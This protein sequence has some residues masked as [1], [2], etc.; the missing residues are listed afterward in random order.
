MDKIRQSCLYYKATNA[1][2][3]SLSII[4]N[5]RARLTV[6]RQICCNFWRCRVCVP[7]TVCPS[8]SSECTAIRRRWRVVCETWVASWC[9]TVDARSRGRVDIGLERTDRWRPAVVEVDR[10]H[11]SA[12]PRSTPC[13]CSTSVSASRPRRTLSALPVCRRRDGWRRPELE[14]LEPAT[15]GRRSRWLMD[16]WRLDSR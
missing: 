13:R 1:R 8:S 12:S 14:L 2:K 16:S 7:W 10:R 9:S 11:S 4:S 15:A 5:V 3:I 6:I